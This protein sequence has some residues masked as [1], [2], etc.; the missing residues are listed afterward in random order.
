L[1]LHKLGSHAKHLFFG[2]RHRTHKHVIFL[3][4][5]VGLLV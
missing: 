4:I 1:V 2:C 3:A 5:E